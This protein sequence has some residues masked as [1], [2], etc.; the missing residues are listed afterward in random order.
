MTQHVFPLRLAH[1]VLDLLL[2]FGLDLEFL[3]FLR[4]LAQNQAQPLLDIERFEDRLF[5][6]HIQF[7]IGSDEIGELR[8]VIEI[9]H[10]NLQ[11]VGE[12]S[13]FP[14]QGVELLGEVAGQRLD[15]NGF[16]VTL[17]VD[18][19][20]PGV[21]EWLLGEDLLQTNPRDALNQKPVG[22]IGKFQHLHDPEHGAHIED[23]FGSRLALD[24]VTDGGARQEA[25]RAQEDRVDQ[26]LGGRRIDED[27]REKKREENRILEGQDR[28]LIGDFRGLLLVLA[29]CDGAHMDFRSAPGRSVKGSFGLLLGGSALFRLFLFF[30][31]VR[32]VAHSVSTFTSRDPA[33][34]FGNVTERKPSSSRALTPV[35]SKGTEI[36]TF[37][38][39]EPNAIS[40]W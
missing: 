2:D 8:G 32:F 18:R 19:S 9:G 17:L 33:I 35:R 12:S 38:S 27:R 37:L 23:V 10:Q 24:F 39:K 34:F 16:E 1:L 36:R 14:H 3:P 15:L 21:K 6:R 4:Q 22:A 31:F 25:I 11:V 29:R 26:L 28:Q 7:E 20:N 5:A 40:I 30:G 13:A